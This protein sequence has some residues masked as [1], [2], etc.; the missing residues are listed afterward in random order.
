MSE[1]LVR[2]DEGI[3]KPVYYASYSMNSSQTRYQKLEK[4]VLA[5]FIISR[6]LK[7]YF[8]TFP[9]TV[10]NEQPE[11]RRGKPG[12][13]QEDF[14]VDLRTEILRTQI[15]AKDSDQRLGLC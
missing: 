15:R 9:I 14:K 3:H 2:E 5:L 10:L 6:K 7:H 11:K 8:Q 13:N 4:L 12:S 1:A